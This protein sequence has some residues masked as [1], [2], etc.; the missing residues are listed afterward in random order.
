MIV[1]LW[2]IEKTKYLLHYAERQLPEPIIGQA[3]PASFRSMSSP[4]RVILLKCSEIR[5]KG[6]Q[7]IPRSV[8]IYTI[9]QFLS[10]EQYNQINF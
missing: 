9:T 5:G 3:G 8:R 1:K 10:K 7:G 4:L 2:L 6:D